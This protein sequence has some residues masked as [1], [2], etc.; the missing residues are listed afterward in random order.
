MVFS[1]EFLKY[2][3][4]NIW[5]LYVIL[6]Y[7]TDLTQKGIHFTTMQ[8]FKYFFQMYYTLHTEIQRLFYNT[9]TVI[10]ENVWCNCEC[11]RLLKAIAVRK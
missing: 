10:C 2:D 8:Y 7:W 11:L 5:I 9:P 3:D 4:H 6:L 1:A